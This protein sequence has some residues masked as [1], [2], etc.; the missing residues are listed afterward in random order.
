[1]PVVERGS[2]LLEVSDLLRRASEEELRLVRDWA[3]ASGAVLVTS[4]SIVVVSTKLGGVRVSLGVGSIISGERPPLPFYRVIAAPEWV[5]GCMLGDEARARYLV[6]SGG[7]VEDDVVLVAVDRS[8]AAA[9][10]VNGVRGRHRVCASLGGLA[11]AK[12][13][14]ASGG[15]YPAL[16]REGQDYIIHVNSGE[17]HRRLMFIV[18]LL[19]HCAGARG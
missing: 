6:D 1:M 5:D 15:E 13:Y 17:A 4:P 9:L 16:S 14:S 19:V 3:I 7:C 18:P 10:L 2:F 8:D 11:V 12:A